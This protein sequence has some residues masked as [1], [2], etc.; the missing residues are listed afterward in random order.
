MV[1]YFNKLKRVKN[2]KKYLYAI[3]G[4]I[5][6]F[7]LY[8]GFK[9]YQD[10]LNQL[11]SSNLVD[12]LVMQIAAYTDKNIAWYEVFHYVE[13][14]KVIKLIN[15]NYDFLDAIS[16]RWFQLYDENLFTWLDSVD[17]RIIK[18]TIIGDRGREP[19]I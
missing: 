5:T 17:N 14:D 13:T 4:L 8:K 10:E 9:D 16:Q 3:G 7:Y 19:N 12:R 2:K 1:S 15:N 6:S 18:E 11:S